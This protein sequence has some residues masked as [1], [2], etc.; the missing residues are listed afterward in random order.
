MQRGEEGQPRHRQVRAPKRTPSLYY[1]N[2]YKNSSRK[3]PTGR[4]GRTQQG[5][6]HGPG[7]LYRAEIRGISG[8]PKELLHFRATERQPG[9]PSSR[10]CG[11]T[12]G[13]LYLRVT[14]VHP[15]PSLRPASPLNAPTLCSWADSRSSWSLLPPGFPQGQHTPI[16]RR[17]PQRPGWPPPALPAGSGWVLAQVHRS[18][19]H[20]AIHPVALGKGAPGQ[21]LWP[22]AAGRLAASS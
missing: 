3:K 2:S 12:P 5:H 15:G 22:G 9:S 7:S 1:T 4:T 19:V 21:P 18:L 6:T 10:L 17:G 13:P 14:Y 16:S 20:L 8:E 11:A